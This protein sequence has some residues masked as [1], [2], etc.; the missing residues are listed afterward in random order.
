MRGE[1]TKRGACACHPTAMGHSF[2]EN[3]FC[4]QV[5]CHVE[6]HP[7]QRRPRPCNGISTSQ[8]RR[9]LRLKQL[10]EAAESPESHEVG[11]VPIQPA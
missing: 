2:G 5:G 8:Y 7:H 11:S 3:L 9:R 10:S 1:D 4:T 6:Y